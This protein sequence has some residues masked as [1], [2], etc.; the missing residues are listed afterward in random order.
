MKKEEDESVS[1]PKI[2]Y[3]S[4]T[5]LDDAPTVKFF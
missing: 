5:S 4:D 2:V 3:E 1:I